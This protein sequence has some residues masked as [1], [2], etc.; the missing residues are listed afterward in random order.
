V[1]YPDGSL[2][3]LGF[4]RPDAFSGL[5]SARTT[6]T[7]VGVRRRT[8]STLWLAGRDRTDAAVE[9]PWLSPA[10]IWTTDGNLLFARLRAS[11]MDLIVTRPDGRE[12]RSTPLAVPAA[13]FPRFSQNG[14]A[15]VWSSYAVGDRKFWRTG[16]NGE[17]PVAL[18]PGPS[19]F[20]GADISSDATW[21]A[22]TTWVS[23]RF[24]VWK[25]PLGGGSAAALLP[26]ESA[27][28]A[29][30]TDGRWVAASYSRTPGDP[31]HVV[32]VPAGGGEP[33]RV[34]DLPISGTNGPRWTADGRVS[35][36][37]EPDGVQNIC[38]VPREGGPWRK[39]TSFTEGAVTAH[40]WSSIGRLLVM[41]SSAAGDLAIIDV[42]RRAGQTE[43]R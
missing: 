38:V 29:I 36:V 42:P 5:V 10:P 25:L 33:V 13:R 19:D 37:C 3:S 21:I 27:F 35:F 34:S 8:T 41:R 28:P 17:N 22:Y 16:P 12:I 4:T 43:R 7:I 11:A 1:S 30:S 26:E 6:S 15:M 9:R 2:R 40:D 31:P 32:V 18:T 39:V 20:F 14:Q 24:A 23:G